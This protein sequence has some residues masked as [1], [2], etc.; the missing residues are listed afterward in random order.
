MKFLSMT[1]IILSLFSSM[2]SADP[3][4]GIWQTVNDDNGNFGHVKIDD[5]RPV[6]MRCF[7]YELW[8]RFK[9]SRK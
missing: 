4:I 8:T 7:S 2:A 6:V 1:T 9:T 3:L 5:L